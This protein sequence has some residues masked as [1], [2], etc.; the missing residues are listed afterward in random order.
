MVA[1]SWIWTN[2]LWLMRP[3]S[4]Q[5]APSCVKFPV[6]LRILTAP[7]YPMDLTSLRR[8]LLCNW[9]GYLIH[10]APSKRRCLHKPFERNSASCKSASFYLTTPT[11]GTRNS[12]AICHSLSGRNHLV[13]VEWFEHSTPCSQS[14]CANQTALHSDIILALSR[15]IPPS[16]RLTDQQPICL[17]FLH[18]G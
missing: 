9:S 5:T 10:G 16:Q 6:R 3:T 12:W 11:P 2:D 1:E 13:R 8:Y 14:R 15:E 7:F 18:A 17:T 4:Y